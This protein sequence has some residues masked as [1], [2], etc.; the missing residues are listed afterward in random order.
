MIVTPAAPHLTRAAV[1]LRAR[2]AVCSAP[3]PR[4]P[5]PPRRRVRA[6]LLACFVLSFSPYFLPPERQ[7]AVYRDG[8]TAEQREERDRARRIAKA[9]YP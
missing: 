2:A 6:L 9:L 7:P 5:R 4:P 3:L 8:M 1:L